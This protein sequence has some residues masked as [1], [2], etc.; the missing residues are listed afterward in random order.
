MSLVL[1]IAL[2]SMHSSLDR[3]FFEDLSFSTPFP[4]AIPPPDIYVSL[5]RQTTPKSKN[6]ASSD[7][8][9]QGDYAG[10]APPRGL[11]HEMIMAGRYQPYEDTAA[12]V[13]EYKALWA[14]AS[15]LK[16]AHE[17]VGGRVDQIL[18]DIEKLIGEEEGSE[19]PDDFYYADEGS[20][21]QVLNDLRE[22]KYTLSSTQHLNE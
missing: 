20:L 16:S 3:P 21:A 19:T 13:Q 2:S 6:A 12:Q 7:G 17:E 14:R 8:S 18:R 15:S 11:L 22:V 5:P 1:D 4:K 10:K 9:A